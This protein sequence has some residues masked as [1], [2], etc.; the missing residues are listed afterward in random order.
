M[1]LMEPLLKQKT[2]VSENWTKNENYTVSA[3]IERGIKYN[4]CA[5]CFYVYQLKADFSQL[6]V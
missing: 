1:K 3:F 6:K 2:I 5:A 4:S